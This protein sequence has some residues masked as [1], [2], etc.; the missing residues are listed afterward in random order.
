MLCEQ[1][2]GA[3]NEVPTSVAALLESVASFSVSRSTL[4]LLRWRAPARD[5]GSAACAV[6][7]R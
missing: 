3:L 1:K 4:I 7:H 5:D 6:R 2:K